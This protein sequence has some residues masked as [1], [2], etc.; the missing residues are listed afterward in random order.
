VI[1]PEKDGSSGFNWVQG[2]ASLTS[3]LGSLIAIT[4]LLR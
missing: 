2:A 4:A 1:V 3:I